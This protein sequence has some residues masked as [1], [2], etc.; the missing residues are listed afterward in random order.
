M[1]GPWLSPYL[2]GQLELDLVHE[3]ESVGVP[4]LWP[5]QEAPVL[6]A[7]PGHQPGYIISLFCGEKVVTVTTEAEG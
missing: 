3:D 2:R 4:W 7:L 1:R 6:M 5:A